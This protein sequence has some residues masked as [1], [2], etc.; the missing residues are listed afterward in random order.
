MPGGIRSPGMTDPSTLHLVADLESGQDE[1]LASE[2]MLDE[3]MEQDDFPGNDAFMEWNRLYERFA[4]LRAQVVE[5]VEAV[6]ADL[7]SPELLALEMADLR[8]EVVELRWELQSFDDLGI[9]EE[10]DI[11]VMIARALLEASEERIDE[12]KAQLDLLKVGARSP[13]VQTVPASAF[14]PLVE[15]DVGAEVT[16]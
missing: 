12:L 3:A 4:T 15:A 2:H 11:R 7:D 10:D 14:L 16:R 6:P 1:L 5:L 8:S 9:T 13:S